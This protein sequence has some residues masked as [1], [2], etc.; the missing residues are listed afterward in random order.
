LL[1]V[2]RLQRVVTGLDTGFGQ[3]PLIDPTIIGDTSGNGVLSASDATLLFREVSGI[4]QPQI[5]PLPGFTPAV[6]LGGPRSAGQP[7]A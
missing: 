7:A 1:D 4:D 5:P 2:T 3:W 6:P